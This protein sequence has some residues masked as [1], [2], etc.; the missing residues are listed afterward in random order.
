ML[1]GLCHHEGNPRI[2]AYNT[3]YDGVNY[4]AD[5]NL[6]MGWKEKKRKT[7]ENRGRKSSEM[8]RYKNEVLMRLDHRVTT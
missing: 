8:K 6:V 4:E 5:D 3:Q 2:D 7:M 1:R